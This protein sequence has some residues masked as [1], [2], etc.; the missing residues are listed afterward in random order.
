MASK[1]GQMPKG[2]ITLKPGEWA[3][4]YLS[5]DTSYRVIEDDGTVT[6]ETRT[7]TSRKTP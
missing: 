5:D 2:V 1:A 7:S 3:L 6:R 4:V